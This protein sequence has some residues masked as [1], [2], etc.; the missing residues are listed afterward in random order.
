MN[1]A[2]LSDMG[3]DTPSI[4]KRRQTRLVE[5]ANRAFAVL[6]FPKV[7]VLDHEHPVREGVGPSTS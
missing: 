7:T 6:S 2:V 3:V 1:V 4:L 5:V